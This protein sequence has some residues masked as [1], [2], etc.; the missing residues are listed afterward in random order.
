MKAQA[1]AVQNSVTKHTVWVCVL[2]Y[3]FSSIV[4]VIHFRDLKVCNMAKSAF[5]GSGKYGVQFYSLNEV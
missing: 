5:P 1:Q 2:V 3:V 4:F